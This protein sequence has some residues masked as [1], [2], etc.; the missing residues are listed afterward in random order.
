MINL[1][2]DMFRHPFQKEYSYDRHKDVMKKL[3]FIAKIEPGDRI[4]V[5]S[6]S[7]TTNT[8]FSAI[9]R[10]IFKESRAKTYQFLN[11]VIDRSFELIVL[12]QDSDKMADR[13][14]C[15]HI[16][17]DLHHSVNGLKN[18]Q[19]TYTDDRSFYCDIDT[20]IGSIFA[21]LAECYENNKLFMTD[22]HRKRLQHILF[23]SNDASIKSDS[24][25][26]DMLK[27]HDYLGSDTK[28]CLPEEEKYKTPPRSDYKPFPLPSHLQESQS[29][30]S[31]PV[32]P[33][34]QAQQPPS[35]HPPPPLPPLP[36]KK[37]S[38]QDVSHPSPR[39]DESTEDKDK[40]N[41]QGHGQGHGQGNG[42][43]TRMQ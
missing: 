35:H 41:N 30:Q 42:R 8:W 10:S 28:S 9:Y 17:E 25:P 29:S 23:P 16:L 1:A 7:T 13:I 3:K 6:I 15:S 4:N 37:E 38:I 39:T 11:E 20:L 33:Q 5:N 26:S 22:D 19:T 18:L 21:R 32:S 34:H 2:I 24:T 14:T 27:H 43:K 31:V 12:Y 40:R 36:L